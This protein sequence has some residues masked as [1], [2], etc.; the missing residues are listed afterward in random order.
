MTA[1]ELRAKMEA[2]GIEDVKVD[3]ESGEITGKKEYVPMPVE[4]NLNFRDIAYKKGTKTAQGE[5]LEGNLEVEAEQVKKWAEAL[6]FNVTGEATEEGV[7]HKLQGLN[8][9]SPKSKKTWISARTN[10]FVSNRKR[11]LVAC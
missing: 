4:I 3:T 2:S 11:K 10:D 5:W 9:K 7:L 8:R 6:G 1:E